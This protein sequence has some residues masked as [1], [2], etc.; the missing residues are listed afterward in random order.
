VYVC[1]HLWRCCEVTPKGEVASLNVVRFRPERRG[2]GKCFAQSNLEFP[3]NR[4]T[5]H[6]HFGPSRN[7]PSARTASATVAGGILLHFVVAFSCVSRHFIFA[8]FPS[9]G[10][11]WGY[12]GY[13]SAVCC[14][15]SAVSWLRGSTAAGVC[16]KN[17]RWG[18]QRTPEVGVHT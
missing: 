13:L 17:I 1:V 5:N 2:G 10:S 18:C 3:R 14:P 12:C 15:L 8:L 9:L 7:A 4:I 11:T 6:T 16:D